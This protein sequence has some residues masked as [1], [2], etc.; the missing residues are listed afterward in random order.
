MIQEMI[1]GSVGVLSRPSVATFEEYEKDN[2]GWALIYSV[3]AGVI[4]AIISGIQFALFP[5]TPVNPQ[6]L[7]DV[8]PELAELLGG[9]TTGAAAAPNIWASVI[10]AIVFTPLILLIAW[11]ITFALGRAF[12]GDG[13]FGELA[14]NMSLFGAPITVIG[15]VFG[16]IPFLGGIAAFA[17]FI[18]NLYLTYLAIQAGMNL[19]GNKALYVILIQFA[20]G[21]AIGLCFF[22]FFALMI[23]ALIGAAG[24]V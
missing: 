10:G 22:L 9:M 23:A 13:K 17:L 3:L 6:D 21:I 5:P 15:S 24:G 18:Y 16:L 11:G 8:P 2:L 7:G 20:I 12:G 19:P 14:Y 4:N 1:N